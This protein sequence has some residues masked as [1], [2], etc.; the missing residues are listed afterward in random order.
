MAA[1]TLVQ[2]RVPLPRRFVGMA[3]AFALLLQVLVGVPSAFWMAAEAIQLS[4]V[5]AAVC[6]H[7]ADDGAVADD[8]QPVQPK[9]AHDHAQ[10]LMCQAHALPLGLLAVLLCVL[11]APFGRIL[12]R[13][14]PTGA[15]AWRRGRYQSYH[16]R[17]PPV[18]A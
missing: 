11:L 4:A 14:L 16:S 12:V 15:A 9:P 8:Q 2:S 1:E 18:A 17:A 5:G 10:C 6:T 3:T 13:G 7:A